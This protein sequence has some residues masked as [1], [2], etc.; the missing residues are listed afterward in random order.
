MRM[1]IKPTKIVN[2]NDQPLNEGF[3][4]RGTLQKTSESMLSEVIEESSVFTSDI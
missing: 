2:T 1:S 4:R 3:F